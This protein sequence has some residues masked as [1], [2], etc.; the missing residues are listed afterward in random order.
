[1]KMTG[2]ANPTRQEQNR[3]DRLP[4][5]LPDNKRKLTNDTRNNPFL[6]RNDNETLKCLQLQNPNDTEKTETTTCPTH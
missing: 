3:H 1:M 2:A 5:T 4:D 6:K